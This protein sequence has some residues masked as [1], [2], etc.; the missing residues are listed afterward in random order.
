MLK[1]YEN[2]AAD[3]DVIISSRVRLARNLVKYP[4]PTR[5]SSTDA[6]AAIRAMHASVFTE[7]NRPNVEAEGLK[8]VD[9]S[10]IS[11]WDLNILAERHII[12]PSMVSQA[13]LRGLVYND[14]ENIS[15]MFNE[16]DHLRIQS[17]F[18]GQDLDAAFEAAN[19][20][21]D[22]MGQNLDYAFDAEFGFLT[23]CPTN[24]GTGLRASYMLHIPLLES[25][26][27]LKVEVG[28]LTK[29]GFTMRGIH[30]EGS[31]SLGSIY[32]ISNQITLGKTEDEIIHELKYYTG[33]LVEKELSARGI[34]ARDYLAEVADSFWRSYGILSYC[35]KISLPEAMRHLSAIR[36]GV[37]LGRVMGLAENPFNGTIY[38]I[39]TN[40]RPYGL[41]KI[42]GPATDPRHLDILRADY[43]RKVFVR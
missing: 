39:M 2:P 37:M 19:R 7:E 27:S 34:M 20:L 18:V 35:R 13:A 21:D 6:S 36:L 17:I 1:W 24:T 32:Q 40:I 23:S 11:N 28:I 41:Q 15:V 26:G 16:E 5:L 8:F 25:T 3:A 4:F 22:L 9:L 10:H 38:N 43:F 29:A 14:N 42:M 30:G 33:Q 31:E 12:S